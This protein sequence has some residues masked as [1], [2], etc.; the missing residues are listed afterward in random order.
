M[1]NPSFCPLFLFTF[2]FTC[3]QFS[4]LA[5][6]C[7]LNILT[8]LF[9]IF[10]PQIATLKRNVNEQLNGFCPFCFQLNSR[11][12]KQNIRLFHFSSNWNRKTPLNS[13]LCDHHKHLASTVRLSA[14]NAYTWSE[15]SK[16]FFPL[17]NVLKSHV[18]VRAYRLDS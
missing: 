16:F 9:E 3:F 12:N 2:Q 13:S 17:I 8:E 14:I 18:L 1:C 4:V 11:Q 10:Y 7:L 6:L 15:F 5:K